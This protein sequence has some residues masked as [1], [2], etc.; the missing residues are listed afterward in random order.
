VPTKMSTPASCNAATLAST[1]LKLPCGYVLKL[2]QRV[3]ASLHPTCCLSRLSAAKDLPVLPMIDVLRTR[4]GVTKAPDPAIASTSEESKTCVN[5][6]IPASMASYAAS[7][8]RTCAMA[9]FPCLCASL[10]VVL[11]VSLDIV[12]SPGALRML[13]SSIMILSHSSLGEDAE[14]IPMEIERMKGGGLKDCNCNE[15]LGEN[16]ESRE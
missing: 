11:T 6:Y 14:L 8:V 4:H 12:G 2:L 9:N 1:S 7:K 5:P 3:C 16:I 10:T 15:K 13:P